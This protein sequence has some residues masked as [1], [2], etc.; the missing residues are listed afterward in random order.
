MKVSIDIENSKTQDVK[1]IEVNIIEHIENKIIKFDIKDLTKEKLDMLTLAI[2]ETKETSYT[3]IEMFFIDNDEIPYF[4]PDY[5]F[6][7]KDNQLIGIYNKD[8]YSKNKLCIKN[9]S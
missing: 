8:F 7:I 5:N 3:D 2:S 9:V 6:Y 4:G 1:T